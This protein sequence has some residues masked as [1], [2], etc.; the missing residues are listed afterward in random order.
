MAETVTVNVKMLK[1]LRFSSLLVS[2]LHPIH[3]PHD[4]IVGIQ[5][6]FCNIEKC[7]PKWVHKNFELIKKLF[8]NHCLLLLLR[9]EKDT[10]DISDKKFINVYRKVIQ[11]KHDGYDNINCCEC[12]T[13]IYTDN[14]YKHTTVTIPSPVPT[15]NDLKLLKSKCLTLLKNFPISSMAVWIS[16]HRSFTSSPMFIQYGI[17][18]TKRH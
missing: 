16:S 5:E 13:R 10:W 12:S 17:L 14:I 18:P 2:S 4:G 7:A 15:F 11:V 3:H 8:Y 1:C 6:G 9:N